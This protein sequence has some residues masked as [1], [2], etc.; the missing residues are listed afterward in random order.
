MR[1]TAV[2]HGMRPLGQ[3]KVLLRTDMEKLPKNLRELHP[4]KIT[5]N[6]KITQLKRNIIFQTSILEFHVNF[7]GCTTML[8]FV[9]FIARLFFL[10]KMPVF[11]FKVNEIHHPDGCLFS[12]I[13]WVSRQKV[14]MEGASNLHWNLAVMDGGSLGFSSFEISCE[15][16]DVEHRTHSSC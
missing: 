1:L 8:F 3:Q 4:L 16:L 14:K 2:F 6:L 13:G 15:G 10:K 12:G 5:W 7:P 11:F 9:F